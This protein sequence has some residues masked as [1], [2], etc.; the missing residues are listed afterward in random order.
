M[1]PALHEKQDKR[2]ASITEPVCP[3]IVFKNEP[4]SALH[5]LRVQSKEADNIVEPS[6]EKQQHDT[7]V[8]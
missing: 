2:D 6:G 1:Q 5:N 3:C 8:T 4:S 7:C